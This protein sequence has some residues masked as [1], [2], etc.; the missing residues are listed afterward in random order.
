MC[1]KTCPQPVRIVDRQRYS[2]SITF[3]LR[4]GLESSHMY[5]HC[6]DPYLAQ[7]PNGLI[8]KCQRLSTAS[9]DWMRSNRRRTRSNISVI[10]PLSLVFTRVSDGHPNYPSPCGG[11]VRARGVLP[12]PQIV[13]SCSEAGSV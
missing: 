1:Q 2:T 13:S 6:I 7:S 11:M 10:S 12:H 9:R 3:M 4:Q 5:L 8:A